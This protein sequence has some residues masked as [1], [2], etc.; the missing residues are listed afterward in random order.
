MLC[1]QSWS[2]SAIAQMWPRSNQ[3]GREGWGLSQRNKGNK[4]DEG[5]GKKRTTISSSPIETKGG[6][7]R[8]REN[9]KWRRKK[10]AKKPS[11]S[12]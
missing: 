1:N 7:G 9:S 5:V 3:M 10:H 2:R 8:K 11:E 6:R 12:S 4:G